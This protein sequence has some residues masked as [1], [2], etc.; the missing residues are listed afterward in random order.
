MRVFSILVIFVIAFGGAAMLYEQ[1]SRK[2][3]GVL[4]QITELQAQLG[5]LQAEVN[6]LRGELEANKLAERRRPGLR[7]M[8]AGS[9]RTQQ[10]QVTNTARERQAPSREERALIA[11]D[12]TSAPPAIR[13]EDAD[14]E[15]S[16]WNRPTVDAEEYRRA[17][18]SGN[19]GDD[20]E[21]VDPYQ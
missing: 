13:R 5:D 9:R 3:K 2:V 16:E 17:D 18:L 20:T 8:A 15:D 14:A 7:E 11:S 1:E 6:K 19:A 12:V 10:A 21:A 4:T